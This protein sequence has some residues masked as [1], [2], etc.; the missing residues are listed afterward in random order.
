V[1]LEEIL[2]DSLSAVVGGQ[3]AINVLLAVAI[4]YMWGLMD[5]FQFII[6]T[7]YWKVQLPANAGS[8]IKTLKYAV[9]GEFIPYDKL[10]AWV[11]SFGPEP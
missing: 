9:L 11:K 3:F 5:T 7:P 4:K 1:R 8:V 6:F 10:L 2:E